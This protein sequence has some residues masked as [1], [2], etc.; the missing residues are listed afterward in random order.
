MAPR[1]GERADATSTDGVRARA[2]RVAA[3]SV[4]ADV[5]GQ[6]ELAIRVAAK[7]DSPMV[8]SAAKPRRIP[9]TD[10]QLIPGPW[11]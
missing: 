11:R 4:R 5:G 9:R 3:T 1:V 7:R 10:L 8:V 2:R 6:I